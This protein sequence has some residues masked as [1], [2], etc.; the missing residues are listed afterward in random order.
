MW[1]FNGELND[2]IEL[3]MPMSFSPNLIPTN[4]NE[5]DVV[6]SDVKAII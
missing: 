4:N 6:D 1:K 3:K 2:F 5:M